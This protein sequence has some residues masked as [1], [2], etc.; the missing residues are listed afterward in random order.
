MRAGYPQGVSGLAPSASSA[1]PPAVARVR[2]PGVAFFCRIRGSDWPPDLR[3][4][5]KEAMVAVS[6]SAQAPASG[7]RA[8]AGNGAPA[9]DDL[10]EIRDALIAA[11]A[12][13]FSRRLSRRRRGPLGEIAA[14]YNG[15]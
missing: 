12:G 11:R 9:A 2:A 7:G 14:A 15:L 10:E 13:D 1:A 4:V 3:R 6:K 8:G 5:N